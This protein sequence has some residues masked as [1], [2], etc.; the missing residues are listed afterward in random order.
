MADRMPTPGAIA[1]SES[2]S[3][4]CYDAASPPLADVLERRKH[5]AIDGKWKLSMQTPMG[6][7]E[8]DLE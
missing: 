7:R 8:V 4:I 5:L 2:H 1:N 6:T 3:K